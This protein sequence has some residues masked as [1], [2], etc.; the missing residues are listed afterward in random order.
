MDLHVYTAVHTLVT[1]QPALHAKQSTCTYAAA[2]GRRRL[3]GKMSPVRA[4][5]VGTA[6]NQSM[7]WEVS[8]AVVGH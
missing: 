5:V 3:I 6:P 1:F 4:G 7:Y 8:S 2:S